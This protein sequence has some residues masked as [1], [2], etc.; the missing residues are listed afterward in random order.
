MTKSRALL[1]SATWA[2]FV[3][4][5]CAAAISAACGGSSGGTPASSN[6]APQPIGEVE[7]TTF[8]SEL[9][10]DLAKMIRRPSGLYV[11][12]L[13][14]GTGTV[15]SRERTLVVRYIGWLP[16]A[17]KF[18]EGEITVTLGQNKVIRAWEDGLLGMRVGGR[19]LLVSPSSLAYGSRGA[20][21]D[22]PP[23]TVLVFVMQ[24]QS[25]Y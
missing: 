7:R 4:L 15:A 18:D 9:G 16:N 17:K 22:V 5:V 10:V 11:E 6:P 12:D 14:A 2:T 1:R 13:A 24:L 8:A 20:G 21:T 3:S 23:N 19:R 25:V